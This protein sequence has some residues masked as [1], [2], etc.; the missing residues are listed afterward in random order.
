MMMKETSKQFV[1]EKYRGVMSIKLYGKIKTIYTRLINIKQKPVDDYYGF[2]IDGNR[3]FLLEDRTITHNTVMAL[4]II[5]QI[6]K[7]TLVVVHKEFLLNQWIE[8]INQFLPDAKVG[9]I[10]GEIIDIEDS[11]QFSCPTNSLTASIQGYVNGSFGNK[12]KR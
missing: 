5:T 10:Q 6:Q 1:L 4:N 3:R 2:C 7:K 12:L 9:K 8:R 11:D